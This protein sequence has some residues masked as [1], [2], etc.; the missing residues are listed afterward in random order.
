MAAIP[1]RGAENEEPEDN[2]PDLDA[3]FDALDDGS[4]DLA[5]ELN[6]PDI[7]HLGDAPSVG[8]RVRGG[9]DLFGEQADYVAGRVTS[10][11]LYAQAA[12]FPTCAQLRVWKWENGIPVGLGTIDSTATEEE[13]VARFITAMPK[14]GEA[15]AQFK[16]R[17][18]DMRGQELGQEVTIVISEHH[19]AVRAVREAEEEDRERSSNPYAYMPPPSNDMSSEMSRMVEHMLATAETRSK[20]LEEALEAERERI[21][22]EELRR[23]QERVDLATNAAQGVQVITERMMKDEAQRA[24]RSARMQ[25]EQSQLL[26]TTLTSIFAQ[27]QSMAQQAAEAARR[28]DEYRIEQERQRADRERVSAEERRKLE[29]QEAEYRRQREREEADYRLRLEREESERKR[30][31]SERL[32]EQRRAELELRVAREREEA[33]ARRRADELKLQHE[34][35]DAQRRFE[36]ARMELELKLNR[37]REEMER[38]E[39]RERDESERRE[40]WFAEERSRRE[41]REATEARERDQERQRQHERMVKELE[42]QAQKDRE[43]A[44]RMVAL[45]KAENNANNG[46][47]LANAAKLFGQFGV[48]PDQIFKR[49]FTPESAAD[50]DED[51]EEKGG[52]MDVVG[53][54]LPVIGEVARA[55]ANRNAGLPPG[56]P[57]GPGARELTP[58]QMAELQRQ[59]APR[60]PAGPRMLPSNVPDQIAM[61]RPRE[62]ERVRERRAEQD[63]AETADRAI[64]EAS[65]P[66]AT[67]APVVLP[68]ID[69]EIPSPPQGI[70]VPNEPPV[71][72]AAPAP[73]PE[74]EYDGSEAPAPPVQDGPIP[75]TLSDL[76]AAKNLPLKAQKSA[77]VGIRKLVKKLEAEDE[78]K[79]EEIIGTAVATEVNIYHYVDA[80]SVNAA[81]REGGASPELTARIIAAMQRSSLIPE[82]FNYGGE[83]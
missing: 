66:V 48:P 49:L 81:I 53:K 72:E 26:I 41:T 46:D 37:E 47:V 9:V 36:S 65:R 50:G 5:D 11:K 73:Q 28:A 58:D 63:M 3:E 29:M 40:R 80:V 56:Q 83:E 25:S 61:P 7:V 2:T 20:A 33:E 76:A 8:G 69:T 23:T 82:G 24:E 19:A 21:R 6:N 62:R 14:K 45:S 39:R 31:E 1:A 42:L 44:E 60:R 34:R 10:P 57:P 35:E 79:W 59:Q 13:F 54:V 75:V 77:R 64:S 52:W 38:K 22:Q 18:I 70:I 71:V 17:P 4:D 27:Q 15:R 43:H 51:A 55:A 12:Q 78:A 68:G 16:L 30:I 32:V 74:P 67:A